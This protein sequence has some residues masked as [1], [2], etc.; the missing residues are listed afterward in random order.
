MREFLAGRVV[1]AFIML[2]IAL[3]SLWLFRH[4]I[5]RTTGEMLIVHDD[6]LPCDAIYVLGGAPEE[7]GR[8]AAHL[9]SRGMAPYMVVTGS[10][11]PSVLLAEGLP[12]T[13]A[14][15][16]RNAALRAGADS[17]HIEMLIKGTSTWE[18]AAA[19]LDHASDRGH[20]VIA[21]VSTEFHMRRVARVFRKR[22]ADT[23][24]EVRLHAANSLRYD[25]AR[26]W[27][28]EEGLLMVNNEYVKLV[29][30]WLRY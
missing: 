25:A 20:K 3:A 8:E 16:S 29:Y 4:A 23:D 18:E 5:L 19:I 12:L 27:A 15:L 26:W 24:I 13:E 21:I 9:I 11:I 6:E 17:L 14:E 22:F 7:R 28:N 2:C 10:N 30:Y 1:L